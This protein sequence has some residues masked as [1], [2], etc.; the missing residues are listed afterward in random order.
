MAIQPYT[1]VVGFLHSP[2]TFKRNRSGLLD[3]IRDAVAL[4]ELVVDGHY[5]L[6]IKQVIPRLGLAILNPGGKMPKEISE[7][8]E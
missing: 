5:L 6:L 8:T 2:L 3:Y 7:N 1:F 4:Y